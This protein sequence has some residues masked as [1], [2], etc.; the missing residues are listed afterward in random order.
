ML[1]PLP[2]QGVELG[3]WLRETYIE[4]HGLLPPEYDPSLM[5][6]RTTCIQR[7]IL[8]LQGVLSGLFPDLKV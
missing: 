8:T 1:H 7:T 4:K 2:T 5:S 6:L 3:T